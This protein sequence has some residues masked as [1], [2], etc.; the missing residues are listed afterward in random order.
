M[1]KKIARRPSQPALMPEVFPRRRH[2]RSQP[3]P[4]A[5]AL[6]R[7]IETIEDVIAD[8]Q[9]RQ[10]QISS[11]IDALLSEDAPDVEIK[12]AVKLFALHSEN[13]SRLGRLLRDQR[14]LSGQASDELAGAIGAALDELSTE[15][16]ITL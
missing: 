3:G 8:V 16:G 11:L 5:P 13:A 2:L 1:P 9:V 15:L 4:E 7:K 6:A 10:Q 12:D 14:A